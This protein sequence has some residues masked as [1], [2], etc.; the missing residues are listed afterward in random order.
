MKL[1]LACVLPCVPLGALQLA[2]PKGTP[3][4]RIL[5]RTWAGLMMGT[6]LT[7][8]GLR[9]INSGDG[10]LVSVTGGFPMGLSP[11]H[12]LSLFVLVK[13]PQG[14]MAARSGNIK[15]HAGI[16]RGNFIGMT[17]AGVFAFSPGRH[18]YQEVF[19]GGGGGGGGSDQVD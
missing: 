7:S 2:M 1:H 11:I 15:V 17:T 13:I 10:P 5:G 16:M 8:F 19:G 6:A 9:D 4:H 14:V 3:T 18:L 12:L